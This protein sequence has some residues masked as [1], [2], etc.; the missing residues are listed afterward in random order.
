MDA[1]RADIYLVSFAAVSPAEYTIVSMEVSAPA[2]IGEIKLPD[3]CNYFGVNCIQLQDM[4][5]QLREIF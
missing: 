5:R 3:A 4:F 1:T 2:N